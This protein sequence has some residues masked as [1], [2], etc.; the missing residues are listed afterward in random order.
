MRTPFSKNDAVYTQRELGELEVGVQQYLVV[1][2][3]LRTLPEVDITKKAPSQKI[4]NPWAQDNPRMEN[5]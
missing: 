4:S 2:Y 5:F 3:A 1:G